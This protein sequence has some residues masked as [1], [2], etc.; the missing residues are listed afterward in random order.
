MVIT[1]YLRSKILP[2]V[3]PPIY[4][5]RQADD[6]FVMIVA[7]DES[8]AATIKGYIQETGAVEIKG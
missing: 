6:H 7:T 1:F 8:Q 5:P 3:E 4:H 2:G